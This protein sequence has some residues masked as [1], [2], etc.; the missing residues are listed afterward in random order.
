MRAFLGCTQT[1]QKFVTY[2]GQRHL[3]VKTFCSID[4]FLLT[5]CSKVS[6]KIA[7]FHANPLTFTTQSFGFATH[8]TVI[9]CAQGEVAS[10]KMTCWDT[11]EVSFYCKRHAPRIVDATLTMA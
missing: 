11:V 6:T 5:Y 4:C 2:R 7:V 9:G 8:V 1:S 10:H 3:A